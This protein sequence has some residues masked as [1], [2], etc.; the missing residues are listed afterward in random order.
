MAKRMRRS[1]RA[2]LNY[3][4]TTNRL[5]LPSTIRI[6]RLRPIDLSVFDD[7]RTYHPGLAHMRPALSVRRKADAD[8]VVKKALPPTKLPHQLSFRVPNYVALC[9]R[10]KV[11]REVIHALD[12]TRKG[13]GG[14][15]R[16]NNWSDVEC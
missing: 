8:V 11:R 13:A 5:R 14:A 15:K 12:L 2:S 7:R 3:A 4:P 10:R 6:V 16:R 9:I 1:K